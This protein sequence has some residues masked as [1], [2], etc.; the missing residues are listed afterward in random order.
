[1]GLQCFQYLE[2]KKGGLEL[3][4]EFTGWKKLVFKVA[5]NWPYLKT[6]MATDR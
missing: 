2:A 1:M 4:D 3:K 5:Y 6:N